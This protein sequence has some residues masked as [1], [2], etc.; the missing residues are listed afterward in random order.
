LK[1]KLQPETQNNDYTNR[2]KDKMNDIFF[3][4]DPH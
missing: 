1:R 3:L 2:M 4:T